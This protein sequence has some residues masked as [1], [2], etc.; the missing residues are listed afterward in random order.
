MPKSPSQAQGVNVVESPQMEIQTWNI[1]DRSNGGTRT[2]EHLFGHRVAEHSVCWI[3]G[4]T[5]TILPHWMAPSAP[6]QI[7]LPPASLWHIAAGAYHLWRCASPWYSGRARTMPLEHRRQIE[8]IFHAA[9]KREP[10]Q[11]PAYLQS[12]CGGDEALRRE[13]EALLQQDGRDGKLSSQPIEK[14]ADELLAGGTA[15]V[16]LHGSI[17]P[18]SLTAGSITPGSMA[19]PYR[20]GERLGAGGMGEVYR[21]Q[22]TRLQRT[23]AIK[24][25]NARFTERF[26]REA[27][28]ISAL[29]H[30][31]ICTLY[32]IGSQDGVGYLVMEYVEGKPLHGPLRIAEALP[33]AIQIASALEA[34]H[35]KGILHRDL[36]PANILVSK[37][38]VKLLDFGLAKFVPTEPHPA[39]ETVTAPLTAIGQILGTLAY[40]SPEQIEGQPADVRSDIFSFGLVLYEMLTGRRAFE[41]SSQTGLMAAILKEEPPPLT[42]LLPSTPPLLDR[43]VRKCLAKDPSKR[44]QTAS[45]LRDEL[46]WVAESESAPL[47]ASP[48]RVFLPWMMGLSAAVLLALV[49]TISLWRPWRAP[50]PSPPDGADRPFVQLDLETGPDEVSQLAV[51]PDGLRIAFVS[52]GGLAIRRLDRAKITP[53]S[54]TEGATSPFFSPDGRWVAFFTQGKLKKIAVDGGDPVTLCDACENSG[55]GGTWG[56][57]DTIV[58]VLDRTGQLSRLSAAGGTPQ[59]FTDTKSDAAERPSPFWPQALPGGKGILF[60]AGNGSGQGS[61]R[62]LT[63]HN[64]LKTLVENA[65]HG[66]YL[67]SG[68]LIYH[69]RG[70]LFAAPMEL[71]RLE[72]TGP[73]V[74]LLEGVSYSG[75]R[76]NFDV[77]ASGT[78]VYQRSTVGSIP[79]WIY[80]SGRIEPLHLKPGNYAT[81]RVSPDGQRL[82]LSVIAEGK[83]NLWV[84]DLV[85]ETLTRLTFAADT[86]LFPA[87]THDGEFLAFRSGNTLAWTRS[88]GSGK[89]EH[90]AGVSPNATPWSFSADGKW[91]TFW[92]L[93]SDSDLWI[94]SVER[95]PGALRLGSPQPLLEQHGSKG[96]PDIS[97]DGRWLAYTS[98]QSGRFQIYVIPFVPPGTTPQGPKGGGKWQVSNE[99]GHGSVWSQNGRALFYQGPDRRLQVAAYTL[100][101]DSFVPGKPRFWGDKPLADIGSF[102]AFDVAPDGTRV[103]AL[104]ASGDTKPETFLRVMF[105]VGGELRRRAPAG[106]K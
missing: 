88:D 91:L 99:E 98:A 47:A 30:P 61:L 60:G 19:G 44:W 16:H 7:A 82:V 12:A 1:G 45:D 101:G 103:L 25:L 79:S 55:L 46:A 70:T 32:D 81:P 37:S 22:D 72:L 104:L 26:E 57:D 8:D 73:P 34:A 5:F 23:V 87:W 65:T 54:A 66:R 35:A 28:A 43:T 52:K 6:F 14:A 106:G 36:K 38:R 78:L 97:P 100:Q 58:A 83:Q 94:A 69:Q 102:P 9:L 105:N 86:D 92:P 17:T 24:T 39:E 85:R 67:A 27:L 20:I 74:P 15:V 56:G 41:A 48:R 29:N 4:K 80:A 53:L 11:R 93:Q 3:C 13:V 76:A 77:S 90:L 51:S 49:A 95:A 21:A 64:G 18:G 50:P 2:G 42:K 75:P 63:P 62:V 96:A 68:Y 71:G 31:H 33:L 59:P 89:V 84:Y 10:A 40:M